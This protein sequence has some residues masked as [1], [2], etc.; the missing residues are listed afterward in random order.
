M[1]PLK[2][3]GGIAALLVLGSILGGIYTLA[4]G[5]LGEISVVTTVAV[6][7]AVVL[8]LSVVGARS[9]RWLYGVYW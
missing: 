8:V 7:A 9:R 5:G 1:H 2:P 3:I 6:V 4:T